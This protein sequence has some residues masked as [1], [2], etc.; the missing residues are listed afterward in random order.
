MATR[1]ARELFFNFN[2][3]ICSSEI[4]VVRMRMG[5]VNE[6]DTPILRVRDI[7]LRWS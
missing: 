5:T 2:D 1:G 4:H 3:N 6:R 7:D